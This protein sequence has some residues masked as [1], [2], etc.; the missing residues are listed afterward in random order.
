MKTKTIFFG[1]IVMLTATVLVSC[2]DTS[3][4]APTSETTSFGA[5]EVNAMA[6]FTEETGKEFRQESLTFG[7]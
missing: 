7:K 4:P 6:L 3:E 5:T 1:L 2:G